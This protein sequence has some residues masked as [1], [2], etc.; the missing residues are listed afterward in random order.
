MRN[1]RPDGEQVGEA[2]EDEEEAAALKH[3][4]IREV[5]MFSPD[6]ETSLTSPEEEEEE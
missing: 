5:R 6:R 3:N 1:P 4:S 2:G